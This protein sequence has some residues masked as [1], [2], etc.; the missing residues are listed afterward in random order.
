MG[1]DDIKPLGGRSA[2]TDPNA[3]TPV[4]PRRNSSFAEAKGKLQT[5]E[6]AQP[7]HLLAIGQFSRTALD[8]PRKLDAM[9]QASVS[10]LIDAGQSVTGRLAE[11]EK[12]LLTDFLSGDPLIRQHI[13]TYLRKAL[14]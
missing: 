6:P 14:L 5:S 2:F 13:E 4:T 1:M 11:P 8:D 7:A 12:K 9:V 10:E 3:E